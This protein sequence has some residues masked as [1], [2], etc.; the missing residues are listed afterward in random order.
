MT[1]KLETYHH[2]I[3]SSL[4]TG[5][6]VIDLSSKIVFVNDAASEMIEEDSMFLEGK[7]LLTLPRIF[8][9]VSVINEHRKNNPSLAVS[10]RQVEVTIERKNGMA[11]PLGCSIT[12]LTDKEEGVLG[13]VILFR[14]LTEINKL[15]TVIKRSEHLAALGTMAAGVAHEIRNP[16]HGIL[17]SVELTQLKLKKNK[18]VDEYLG[19][20]K[21][22]VGRLNNIVE[23]I[24]GFSRNN[25]LN[26]EMIDVFEFVKMIAPLFGLSDNIEFELTKD[27]SI[28][29][30]PLDGAKFT[31]VL[32]NVVRN[33]DEAM[34]GSGKLSI[35]FATVVAPRFLIFEN[36]LGDTFLQ[37]NITDSGP[38]MDEETMQ[39][40]FEP[41]FSSGKSSNGTGLG[42]PICQKIVQAHFGSIEVTSV[43]G[44]G[45]TFSIYLPLKTTFS[46]QIGRC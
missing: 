36:I 33:S 10:G 11:L 17:A 42:L 28:P 18:P 16:L 34:D 6:A 43:L 12:N 23:D 9:F 3:L 1:I 4:S 35:S 32:I 8:H 21:K 15:K 45:T 40:I 25:P 13:Y 24:L 44:A 26:F 29:M 14:D 31:Q 46:F 5:V 41:F 39:H 37:I 22:E 30:V 19:I 7:S 38:G 20:I 2:R 27:E